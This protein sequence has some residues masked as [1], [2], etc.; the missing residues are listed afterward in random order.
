MAGIAVSARRAS[1]SPT[2]KGVARFGLAA[3]AFV[4]LVIGWLAVQIARGQGSHEANQRGAVAEVAQQP[5]GTA[6]LWILGLGLAAYSIWRFSEAVFGTAVD[7][8]SIGP[9]L[10]SFVRGAVYAAFCVGTFSFLAG[11]WNRGQAQQ[12]ASMTAQAM[13]HPAGRWLVGLIGAAVFVV[14]VAM[15]VQGATRRFENDLKMCEL[16]RGT[17]RV[18]V[19][20]GVVG[21]VARGVVFAI[22]GGLVVEAA[23]RFEPHKSTGLDGALRTM[24]DRTDGQWLLAAFAVGLITFGLYGFAAARWAKT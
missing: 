20:L 24:A 5:F 9:R 12:Q 8:S 23:V 6:L 13:S 7:G 1:R 15:V 18:V 4:Y 2:L 21:T 14:G 3:R 17:R 19:P 22:A 16:S 10:F 11:S